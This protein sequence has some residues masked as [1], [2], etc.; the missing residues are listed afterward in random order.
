MN[1]ILNVFNFS[2]RKSYYLTHPWKWI[3]EVR[4][5]IRNAWRRA[6]KGFAPIDAYEFCDYLP[7]VT[8]EILHFL[9]DHAHGSP[10]NERFPTYESWADWLRNTADVLEST[11]EENWDGQNEYEKQWEEAQWILYPHPNFTVTSTITKEDAE[12][13]RQLYWDREKEL[14]EQRLKLQEKTLCEI[15]QVLPM[16]WD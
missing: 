5:N 2:F 13:M 3:K 12:I 16:I 15:A 4:I 7:R 6:T 9:A 8:A 1:N 14:E 11:L 10:A